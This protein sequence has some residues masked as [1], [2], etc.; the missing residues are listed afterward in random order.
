MI[1]QH[2]IGILWFILSLALSNANDVM[3]KLLSTDL[4]TTILVFARF[5]CAVLT[6]LPFMWGKFATSHPNLH[7]LRGTIL[8]AAMHCWIFGIGKVSITLA[9]LTT[10]TIPIFTIILAAIFLRERITV[11]IFLATFLGFI[12]VLIAYQPHDDTML[13]HVSLFMLF[14]ALLFASLDVINKKFIHRE[15]IWNMIFYSNLV[16]L[17]WA[18][19]GFLI[20]LPVV[21]SLP[22]LLLLLLQGVNSNLLLFCILQAFKRVNANELAPYRYLELVLSGLCGYLIFQEIP[23][24]YFL[25]GSVI[26][27]ITTLWLAIKSSKTS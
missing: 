23:S 10:F 8:F 21:I 22:E 2:H 18:T 6:L 16:T 5:A 15:T 9:T 7:I 11:K 13:T 17:C 1:Q 3:A 25:I 12:G 20:A 4:P 27:V 24:M 14:S 26:T 19:P